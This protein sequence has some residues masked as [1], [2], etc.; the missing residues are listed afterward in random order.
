MCGRALMVTTMQCYRALRWC[1]ATPITQQSLRRVAGCHGG[2]GVE[3]HTHM[4]HARKGYPP[5]LGPGTPYGWH[6]RA[7]RVTCSAPRRSF[8]TYTVLG[9]TLGCNPG[10]TAIPCTALP[11]DVGSKSKWVHE[12]RQMGH[13]REPWFVF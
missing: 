9:D 4:V 2:V 13:T 5:G 10:T 8:A 11:L 7:G 3:R 1:P 12:R 6:C